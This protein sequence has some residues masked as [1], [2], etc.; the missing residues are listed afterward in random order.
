MLLR[1]REGDRKLIESLIE[2]A[3][4]EYSE[5]ANVQPP[6]ITIDERVYLP[7]APKNV[8]VD[9]HEPYWYLLLTL[10]ILTMN[11]L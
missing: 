1:C 5:K 6:N 11:H 9:S 10:L 4:K 7:P 2:E 3:K 8:A